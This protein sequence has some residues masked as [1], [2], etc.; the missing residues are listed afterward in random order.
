MSVQLALYIND[1]VVKYTYKDL[2]GCLQK[3]PVLLLTVLPEDQPHQQPA[4]MLLNLILLLT[5]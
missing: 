5:F 4:M 1:L 2:T 3:Y